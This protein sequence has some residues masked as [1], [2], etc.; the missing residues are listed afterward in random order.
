MTSNPLAQFTPDDSDNTGK[1]AVPFCP[2][3]RLT[4][5]EAT[6]RQTAKNQIAVKYS[7]ANWNDAP[8]AAL[9]E[10]ERFLKTRMS[11]PRKDEQ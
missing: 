1:D 6:A 2:A 3:L 4:E 9:H 5:Q 10:Y 7:F 8:A 11:N